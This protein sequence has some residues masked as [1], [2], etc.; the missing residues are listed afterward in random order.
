MT[1]SR[2][3]IIFGS[4]G[5]GKTR[6]LTELI[7]STAKQHGTQ[8]IIA[9]SFS[10]AAATELRGR[11][12]GVL[13][14][15]VHAYALSLLRATGDTRKVV[16]DTKLNG[17]I[18]R[19]Y[20]HHRKQVASHIVSAQL[21]LV[22]GRTPTDSQMEV[23]TK[24]CEYKQVNEYLDFYD[25]L[26]ATESPPKGA[27]LVVDEAQ[28]LSLMQLALVRRWQASFD[29]FAMCGDPDQAIYIFN[30]A[31]P[32]GMIKA[33][34]GDVEVINL[35][36]GYRVPA[37]IQRYTDMIAARIPDRFEKGYAPINL[38]GVLNGFRGSPFERAS[39]EDNRQGYIA[40]RHMAL[41]ALLNNVVAG[42][43]AMVLARTNQ[44]L[45]EFSDLLSKRG[46]PHVGSSS[47]VGSPE[48]KAVKYLCET[49]LVSHETPSP[50]KVAEYAPL[51]LPGWFDS[52]RPDTHP[53][54]GLKLTSANATLRE[55][56]NLTGGNPTALLHIA[57]TLEL[58]TFHGSKGHEADHV[59][60]FARYTK[61]M[62]ANPSGELNALYVACT[63]AKKSLTTLSWGKLPRPLLGLV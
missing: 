19:Y 45:V 61:R 35:D 50:A 16:D 9:L 3:K 63:R 20:Q 55:W 28:D 43:T 21:A 8:G 15:T 42:D 48:F 58:T 6:Y 10:K 37:D 22:Q 30:G 51:F 53:A 47:P 31:S 18:C 27:L 46:I 52:D 14:S 13:C 40:K 32:M 11:N 60:V 24:Y 44:Q 12:K 29:Y 25:M 7:Q 62:L 39:A 1:T 17:F 49:V 34:S 54:N 2:K 4:P 23:Y 41:S 26:T 57:S 36:K 33:A 59:L 56:L 38:G 5:T